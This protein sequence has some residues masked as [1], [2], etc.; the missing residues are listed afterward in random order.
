MVSGLPP[1]KRNLL[2]APHNTP[3]FLTPNDVLS[4]EWNVLNWLHLWDLLVFWLSKASLYSA[5][6]FS[7]FYLTIYESQFIASHLGVGCSLVFGRC[8]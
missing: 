3:N 4:T 8:M 7:S 5:R 1:K 2:Y 6:F